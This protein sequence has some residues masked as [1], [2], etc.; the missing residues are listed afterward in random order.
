MDSYKVEM[1][2]TNN[3]SRTNKS[4]KNTR[5]QQINNNTVA[6][7]SNTFVSSFN[8]ES[9]KDRRACERPWERTKQS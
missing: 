1:K 4:A 2:I 5:L 9:N 6:R 3:K 8:R 7:N